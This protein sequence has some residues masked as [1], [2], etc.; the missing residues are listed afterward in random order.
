MIVVPNQRKKPAAVFPRAEFLGNYA[1][2]ADP[3]LQMQP[4]GSPKNTP[5]RRTIARRS[6]R[7]KQAEAWAIEQ[8]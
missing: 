7:G 1:L 8:R 6:G 2:V 3:L 5:A 4:A